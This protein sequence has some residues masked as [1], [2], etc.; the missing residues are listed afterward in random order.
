MN[1]AKSRRIQHISNRQICTS[2]FVLTLDPGV[3]A[4]LCQAQECPPLVLG[5]HPR[6]SWIH[7]ALWPLQY[8]Y[9]SHLKP[10]AELQSAFH[11]CCEISLIS[12]ASCPFPS[13]WIDARNHRDPRHISKDIFGSCRR[14]NVIVGRQDYPKNQQCGT[15]RQKAAWR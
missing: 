5:P 15:Y 3:P 10:S 2:F 12:A 1:R 13:A 8:R 14:Q 6:C 9:V 7:T 11:L 4:L